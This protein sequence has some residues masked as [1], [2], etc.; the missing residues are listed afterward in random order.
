M[1]HSSAGHTGRG[2]GDENKT[3]PHTQTHTHTLTHTLSKDT[4]GICNSLWCS[5][6]Q[7]SP[8]VANSQMPPPTGD[9][10]QGWRKPD[11]YY[12]SPCTADCASDEALI[13]SVRF[14]LRTAL[15]NYRIMSNQAPE[16]THANSVMKL[17]GINK[18][19]MGVLNSWQMGSL[20]SFHKPQ[21]CPV[22]F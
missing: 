15:C 22:P 8:I 18:E 5:E 19:G 10:P 2:G 14:G 1:K 6:I 13:S 16:M 20:R 4:D 3:P 12:F 17:P 7:T 21:S 9:F 11:Y